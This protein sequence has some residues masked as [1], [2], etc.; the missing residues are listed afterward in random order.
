MKSIRALALGLSLLSLSCKPDIPGYPGIRV[1]KGTSDISAQDSVFLGAVTPGASGDFVFTIKNIGFKSDLALSASPPVSV[2]GDGFSVTSQPASAQLSAGATAS[3]TI[4]FSPA[5]KAMYEGT[6]SISSNDPVSA[7]LTFGIVGSGF[8]IIKAPIVSGV[9]PTLDR[10]PTWSWT[11]GGGGTGTFRY[12]LDSSDLSAGATTTTQTSFTPAAALTV[13]EHTL[14]V[15]EQNEGGVWSE[16]GSFLIFVDGVHA[17]LVTGTT[18]TANKQPTWSWATGGNGTGAFRFK[19]D[20]SDLTSGA[21]LTAATSYTPP[22][23]LPE[24]SHTLY[25]QEQDAAGDWSET[26]SFLISVETVYAAGYFGGGSNGWKTTGSTSEGSGASSLYYPEGIYVDAAGYTFVADT[27][28]NR[29]SKWD[30]NGNAAGWIGGGSN[31]WKTTAAPA[32]GSGYMSFNSPSGVYVDSTG[33]IYVADKG[34]HRVC[35]WDIAGNALG[36]IGGAS[37]GWKTTA[38]PS[39]STDFRSFNEPTGVWLDS[40]GYMYVADFHNYRISKWNSAGGIAIGWI[41]GGSNGWKTAS[42]NGLGTGYQS[43]NC[44]YKVFVDLAGMIYVADYLGNRVLKWDSA[45]TALGWLGGGANGWNITN[46]PASG[47]SLNSFK[48]PQGVF[49]DGSGFIYVADTDNHRVSKWDSSGNAIGWIG[50]ASNGW[51]TGS[52]SSY[53]T[54]LSGLVYPRGVFVRSDGSI[55]ITGWGNRV[56]KWLPRS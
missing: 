10:T 52:G 40:S 42:G 54:A 55:Y 56:T 16:S 15:Q 5:V 23:P 8:D 34:N 2:S 37:D 29:I 32:S 35:K 49:V 12:A 48:S 43:F 22:A 53:S 4:R 11:S 6:V 47:S 45:G 24:G 19:L 26:G 33:N 20:S 25:A 3:F 46:A 36:W 39:S 51:Q 14:Y 44:P 18:P 31:G 9:T 41:G 21:T 27:R 1:Q 30:S 28:N 7:T 50:G 13:S 17:P 38:S